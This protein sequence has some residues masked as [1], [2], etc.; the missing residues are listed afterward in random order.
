MLKN[1]LILILLL[2]LLTFAQH[3]ISGKFS[4]AKDFKTVILYKV[5]PTQ[6]VY[7]SHSKLDSLG[8]FNMSIKEGADKGM[9]KM[10][11]AA[12]QEEYN[13]NIIYNNEDINFTFN[14]NDGV[15]FSTSDEN[16]TMT[17]YLKSMQQVQENFNEFFKHDATNEDVFFKL[18]QKQKEIQET[19]EI[20]SLHKIS[21]QFI[22][23]NRSFYPKKYINQKVYRN[24]LKAHYFDFLDFNNLTLLN[25]NTLVEKSFSYIFSFICLLYTSPSPRDS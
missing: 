12:P 3:Q 24:E 11:Y 25:S 8:Q 10:V 23:A 6:L 13:F 16:K 9:Y 4:P 19:Y 15:K 22:K 7:Q 17:S 21:Y 1:R 2:P 20:E 5:T 14:Q 18:L